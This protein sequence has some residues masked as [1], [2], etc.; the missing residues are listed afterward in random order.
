MNRVIFAGAVLAAGL[1]FCC[2]KVEAAQTTRYMKTYFLSEEEADLLKRVG[3]LEAGGE[4]LEGI[5]NVMQVVLNRR[6]SQDFPNTIEECLY[7]D[8]QF[9]TASKLSTTEI[10]E[11]AEEALEAVTDGTYQFNDSLYFESLPGKVWSDIHT[12]KFSY[13]GHDFYK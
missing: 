7:Q 6:F 8:G 2:P 9:T 1:L 11:V 3:V 12:Y 13:G 4:D 10:T 5:A